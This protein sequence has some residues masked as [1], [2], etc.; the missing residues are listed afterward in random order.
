[1]H[2][3]VDVTN[4][5]LRRCFSSPVT[6]DTDDD[7]NDEHCSCHPSWYSHDHRD[8]HLILRVYSVKT[9]TCIIGR[10]AANE[11]TFCRYPDN[12]KWS[13]ANQVMPIV[14]SFI[15]A[16]V[17]SIM[18]EHRDLSWISEHIFRNK[19]FWHFWVLSNHPV[20]A[21][22]QHWL[23]DYSNHDKMHTANLGN[24]I[25]A[26]LALLLIVWRYCREFAIHGFT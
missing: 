11:E 23:L 3:C 9:V 2:G 21:A 25:R 18:H 5:L 13:L 8:M 12:R 19:L 17:Y 22:E 15:V 6:D 20:V 4:L 7:C 14:S 24:S 1:M 16:I 26:P 10:R